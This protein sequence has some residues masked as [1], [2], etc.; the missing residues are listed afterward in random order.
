MSKCCS[1]KIELPDVSAVDSFHLKCSQ[2]GRRW[3]SEI[4]RWDANG[5]AKKLDSKHGH[6]DL[7]Y[8]K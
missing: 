8:R 6:D 1:C 4:D 3:D 2:V 7:R 5:Q